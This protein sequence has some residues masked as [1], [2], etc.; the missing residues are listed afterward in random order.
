MALLNNDLTILLKPKVPIQTHSFSDGCREKLDKIIAQL[1]NLNNVYILNPK[2]WS[3]VKVIGISDIVVTQGMTSSSTIAIISGVEGLYFDQVHYNHPFSKIFKDKLVFDDPDKLIEMTHKIILG[4]VSPLKD[5][6]YYL[7]REYDECPD[8]RSIELLQEFLINGYI[9]QRK[10]G[11]IIQA[12]MGST[13]LPGKIM[14]T[15]QNKPVLEHIIDRLKGCK[16][17]HEI[18]IATTI[19]ARDD[20]IVSLAKSNNL[21]YFRGSEE[22]VLSRYYYAAK[23]N[24]L[25]VIIRI[26]SDC[27]FVDADIIDSMV[28]TFLKDP[29]VDYLSN[30]IKRTFPRGLD[31][32]IMNFSS[33]K[34][35]FNFAKENCQREHV[36]P[37]IYQN[38]E[39]FKIKQF[40]GNG[41]DS[42]YRLTLDTQ[43]DFELIREIYD[44]IYPVNNYFTLN[45]VL[46]FLKQHDHLTMLNSHIVQK[47][48]AI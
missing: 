37:Y 45:D 17:V 44:G 8:D 13:R 34:K 26:T 24:N 31:V 16:N 4:E 43:E 21:K 19:D 40:I 48:L 10:V 42:K 22:D 27:P 32:E 11:I 36:T 28:A 35:A 47:G 46:R 2:D 41:D 18:I 25:D 3:Y 30:T 29:S 23:E 12:R 20:L 38:E 14:L 5:I 7:L 1:N 33:L 9:N 15:V 39:K 6:P